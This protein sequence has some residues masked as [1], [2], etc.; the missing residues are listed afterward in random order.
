MKKWVPLRPFQTKPPIPHPII[1]WLIGDIEQSGDLTSLRLLRES[2]ISHNIAY[3]RNSKV[4]AT[5]LKFA[6][7]LGFRKREI[8]GLRVKHVL[9]ANQAV[10]SAIVFDD[11]TISIPG[12]FTQT[13][14][15]Y[16][17][18]LGKYRKKLLPDWPFFS[19]RK[20]DKP[21]DEATIVRHINYFS[22]DSGYDITIEKIRQSG[23]CR[24]YDLLGATQPGLLTGMQ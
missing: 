23:I 9:D 12:S 16:C 22:K 20:R 13:V 3:L 14:I 2:K 4:L 6:Y 7:F 10:H 24:F 15:D 18:Y 11:E 1:E 17:S 5:A 19:D 8:L 21:Y